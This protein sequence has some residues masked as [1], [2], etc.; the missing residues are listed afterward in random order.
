M[1]KLEFRD[2]PESIVLKVYAS[3]FNEEQTGWTVYEKTK[4]DC[5]GALLKMIEEDASRRNKEDVQGAVMEIA[6]WLIIQLKTNGRT[7]RRILY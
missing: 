2:A 5:A 7:T 1:W 3:I 4:Q 6:K